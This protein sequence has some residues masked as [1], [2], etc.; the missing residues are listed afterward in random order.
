MSN[1]KNLN[2]NG[3]NA[4]DMFDTVTAEDELELENEFDDFDN[5]Y[6]GEEDHVEND[7]DSDVNYSNNQT[8]TETPSLEDMQEEVRQKAEMT[9][10]ELLQMSSDTKLTLDH[11]VK[12]VMVYRQHTN[13]DMTGIRRDI[14]DTLLK[15]LAES[16]QQGGDDAIYKVM[17]ATDV[18]DKV[19][20]KFISEVYPNLAKGVDRLSE[21][22]MRP[23]NYETLVTTLILSLSTA[24][25]KYLEANIPRTNLTGV[26]YQENGY[27][28]AT[29]VAKEVGLQNKTDDV[30]GLLKNNITALKLGGIAL[31]SSKPVEVKEEPKEEPKKLSFEEQL[32]QDKVEE[33]T[34]SIFKEV[35]RI[36]SPIYTGCYTEKAYGVLVR[37]GVL[38][39]GYDRVYIDTI[40]NVVTDKIVHAIDNM[41]VDKKHNSLF[42]EP[43]NPETTHG[44]FGHYLEPTGFLKVSYLPLYHLYNI[45]RLIPQ[46]D[47]SV[48][49]EQDIRKFES[50]VKKDLK[51]K[52]RRLIEIGLRSKCDEAIL[53]LSVKTLFTTI[54]VVKE[55][56]RLKV[57]SLTYY[58]NASNS[59]NTSKVGDMYYLHKNPTARLIDLAEYLDKSS[60]IVFNSDVGEVINKKEGTN[61]VNFIYAFDKQAYTSE[62]LFAYKVYDGL[63][64]SGGKV[65][66]DSIIMGRKLDGTPYA[67]NFAAQELLCLAI[68]AGS[69]SGKGVATMNPVAAIL[70]TGA[71]LI[72]LD[73]KPDMAGAF[74][75]LEKQYDTRFLAIDGGVDITSKG[76]SINRSYDWE[77]TIPEP[78]KSYAEQFDYRALRNVVYLKAMLLYL[79]YIRH[80]SENPTNDKGRFYA[81]FDELQSFNKAFGTI[82][83]NI[84]ELGIDGRKAKEY[85]ENFIAYLKAIQ[86]LETSLKKEGDDFFSKTGGMG[87]G[88]IIML[89]QKVNPEVWRYGKLT[90]GRSPFANFLTQASYRMIGINHKATRSGYSLDGVN[91]EGSEF[92]KGD[93]KG[94][95][96][97]H[98]GSTTPDE[99]SAFTT[100]KSY[101]VLNTND[102]EKGVPNGDINNPNE[103]TDTGGF[104]KNF[105]ITERAKIYE[106]ELLDKDGSPN[107]GV[108]FDGL[109][110]KTTALANGLDEKDPQVRELVAQN[111][112]KGYDMLF[113][114]MQYVGLTQYSTIEEYLY[115]LSPQSL[116]TV[117]DLANKVPLQQQQGDS[118]DEED[119]VYNADDEIVVDH[120]FEGEGDNHSLGGQ[121]IIVPPVGVPVNNETPNLGVS[122]IQ[123]ENPVLGQPFNPAEFGSQPSQPFGNNQPLEETG[124]VGVQTEEQGV[125]LGVPMSS[126]QSKGSI[127]A[128]EYEF[129]LMLDRGFFRKGDSANNLSYYATLERTSDALLREIV[130]AVGGLEG[131]YSVEVSG[132]NFYVNGNIL[133]P[134]LAPEILEAMPVFIANRVR[135]GSAAELFHAGDLKK[136]PNL[137]SLV[138]DSD[139]AETRFRDEYIFPPALGWY[140]LFKKMKS[141][142]FLSVGGSQ[143]SREQVE[144][145]EVTEGMQATSFS[146]QIGS[147]FRNTSRFTR[148][149]SQYIERKTPLRVIKNA[150]IATAATW[151]VVSVA[152]MLGGWGLLFGAMAGFGAYKASKEKK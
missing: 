43:L 26:L 120:D 116:Y 143:W 145:R 54:F 76:V 66:I 68:I 91:F 121:S 86:R 138:M 63:K 80:R 41:Y 81:V 126:T 53:E 23:E 124:N 109:I 61:V 131:V 11:V 95:F 51:G 57:L 75:R 106:D 42:R 58:I 151:G 20:L 142:Q 94:Y 60:K 59:P 130:R 50:Y 122:T 25:W 111:M 17:F 82:M 115:D 19:Y 47:G 13:S 146:E 34:S 78:V 65:T 110:E 52:I 9:A 90:W 101:F 1:E 152:S 33:K 29:P 135:Q 22:D 55:L 148:P 99:P 69:R 31:A 87:L 144:R 136:F 129:N 28:S 104:I 84:E 93:S 6:S 125:A 114:Y 21:K 119:G 102:V 7:F 40:N 16:E 112:R 73:F 64:E 139:Y 77:S 79:A 127:D 46:E 36:L 45:N 92:I 83:S 96:A 74:W 44:V 37:Q 24:I 4:D 71:P 103:K 134:Q 85:D 2:S 97:I 133:R 105:P 14:F 3:Y 67:M 88:T 39:Y 100:I 118:L 38:R 62:L 15:Q 27:I 48:Y 117:N 147:I 141:L 56:D 30:V 8:V 98:A 107:K 128:P 32:F 72:Y 149:T 18:S 89:G 70:G 35:W 49:Y 150:G 12:A 108:G 10:N 132:T 5:N 113:E 137:R 123:E 140:H